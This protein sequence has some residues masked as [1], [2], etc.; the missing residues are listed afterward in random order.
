M[1]KIID[2]D[3]VSGYELEL[4]FSDG[5]R[6]VA[7]LTELFETEAFSQVES[8]TEFS[9][10]GT[11]IDWGVAEISATKLRQLAEEQGKYLEAKERAISPDDIEAVLKQAAW[12]SITLN[13]PDILQ[14]AIRGYIE[15][16]GV[17]NVQ[18]KTNLKSRPSIYK[19]LSPHTSPKFDTLVQLAH[20]A[21][22]VKAENEALSQ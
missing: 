22:A 16:Y 17:Q 14:A 10:E 12:D 4:E 3:W 11:Y 15:E 8:F 2:V 5:F 21:L 9:L 1:L 13:R 7:D 19:A 18:L 6:G 20:G